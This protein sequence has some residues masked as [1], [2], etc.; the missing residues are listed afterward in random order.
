[1][2]LGAPIFDS[3]RSPEEWVAVCKKLG[4]RAAYA[5]IDL[6]ASDSEIAEYR[7][8]AKENDIVIAEVSAFLN[9]PFHPDPEIADKSL[10]N[11]IDRMVFA[12]KLGANC[13]VNVSSSRGTIWDGPHPLNL[14]EE[15][16]EMTVRFVRKVLDE[17]DPHDSGYALEFMP[18]MYP[19]TVDD[20]IRLLEEVDHPQFVVHLDPVNMINSPD[21]YYAN[22]DIIRDCFARLGEKIVGV[23]CKDIRLS[24]K[25]TVHLDEVLAG[26]GELDHRALLTCVETMKPDCPVLMEHLASRE[27]YDK[28]VAYIRGLAESMGYTTR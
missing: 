13:C 14:T 6:G 24:T 5:P 18:W 4:Y 10:R 8:A 22:G 20:H 2:R 26:E 23:H 3:Y 15:T 16:F 12:D 21:K 17:A 19:V 11:T 7:A 25:L 1:M 28:A 27:L 9:H